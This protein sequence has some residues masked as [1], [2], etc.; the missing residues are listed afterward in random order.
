MSMH[1]IIEFLIETI[2]PMLPIFKVFLKF[3]TNFQFFPTE[4]ANGRKHNARPWSYNSLL[5]QNA[6]HMDIQ[7]ILCHPSFVILPLVAFSAS[8]AKFY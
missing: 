7:F 4:I 5:S 6:Q 8:G 2:I 1:L 3:Q